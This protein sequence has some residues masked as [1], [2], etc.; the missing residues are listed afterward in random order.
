FYRAMTW[1]VVASPCALV[2][3]TP[4]SILSAIAN[5][6]RNGVLFKGGVHLEKA[7]SLKVVAFDK[8]GTLTHGIPQL[9]GIYP[10]EDLDEN[11]LLQQVAAVEARSE[12]PLG[13]AI[14]R[15]AQERALSLPTALNFRAFPGRGVEA[16]VEECHWLVGNVRLFVE[17]GIP[18]PPALHSRIQQLEA[19]GQTVML[20]YMSNLSG[21]GAGVGRFAGLLT[22]ADAL[23]SEAAAVVQALKQ[24]GIE[25]V[26]ML[27][28]DN[29]R[30]AARIAAR[31]GVDAYYANLLP[32][33]KVRVLRELRET[34][35]SVAMIG[36]GV[37]DAPSLAAADLGIAMGLSLIHI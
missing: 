33:D 34:Y 25:R 28:G 35:G 13:A 5:G 26:V 4:A 29:E 31:T 14:V 23:R 27:T 18:I 21:P 1:L 19:E 3:S 37:N 36:D 20:A 15:M 16:Q 10:L 9:T 30:V 32:Q 8:T 24:V 6:A 22:V 2:I 12:H 7:A 17:R 11:T